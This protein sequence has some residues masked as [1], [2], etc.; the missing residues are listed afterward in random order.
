MNKFINFISLNILNLAAV[1]QRLAG[2]KLS[3]PVYTKVCYTKHWNSTHCVCCGGL[4]DK[5]V[6]GLY[7]GCGCVLATLLRKRVFRRKNLINLTALLLLY[8][9]IHG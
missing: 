4:H 3:L 6:C 8:L 9:C 7:L 5:A 1:W 2:A